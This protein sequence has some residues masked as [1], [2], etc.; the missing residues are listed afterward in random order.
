MPTVEIRYAIQIDPK[1]EAAIND[2]VTGVANFISAVKEREKEGI[3]SEKTG[4]IHRQLMS[5]IEE[6]VIEAATRS[7]II[8]RE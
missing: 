2:M 4:E 1:I 8:R 6:V 3:S 5:Q 7:M